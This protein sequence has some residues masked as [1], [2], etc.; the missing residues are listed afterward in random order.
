MLQAWMGRRVIDRSGLE[1]RYDIDFEFDFASVRSVPA[2]DAPAPSIF[3]ALQDRLGLKLVA[4]REM[5]EVLVIDAAT[6]PMP[7]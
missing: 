3:V 2:A 6:L 1:G 5:A 4:I 7:N